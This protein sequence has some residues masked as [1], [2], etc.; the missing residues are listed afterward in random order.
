MRASRH[1]G[2]TLVELA[3]VLVII[4]LIV[5]GILKGAQL[6]EN[7]R[8]ISTL[9]QVNQY[10][11]GAAA[12]RQKYDGIAGDYPFAK[13]R[14]PTCAR[15]AACRDG[16]GDMRIGN[17]VLPIEEW[18]V[19]NLFDVA[20]ENTQF[21][22][23][24]AATDMIGGITF[25]PVVGWMESHPLASIQ[26]GGFVLTRG[27]S[28][29]PDSTRR[30]FFRLQ[31]FPSTAPTGGAGTLAVSPNLMRQMDEKVDDGNPAEG[32]VRASNVS[33]PG[34]CVDA[35]GAYMGHNIPSCIGFFLAF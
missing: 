28:P 18:Y 26:T 10:R 22:Y 25:S 17:H 20:T 8:V 12:F 13:E 24:L 15:E 31:P 2:F 30:Y 3:V 7:S 4:G 9:S 23:H 33:D 1:A 19:E 21:W 6:I 16:D 34:L 35:A 5:G 27:A 14:I 29:D 11:A 32:T